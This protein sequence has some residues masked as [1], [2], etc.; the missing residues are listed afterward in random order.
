MAAR[1]LKEDWEDNEIN[2]LFALL[3][4]CSLTN[5][6]H[7]KYWIR[8]ICENLLLFQCMKY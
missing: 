7:I 1:C 4:I 8:P 2:Q 6:R 5:P 3:I